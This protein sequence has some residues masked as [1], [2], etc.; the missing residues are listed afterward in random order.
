ML[1][2]FSV[3]A[4]LPTNEQ[5]Q[6]S[7]EMVVE[8]RVASPNDSESAHGNGDERV[9][10]A[11]AE[12][13]TERR[14]CSSTIFHVQHWRSILRLVSLCLFV[15]CF[16]L[17]A[18]FPLYFI[19]CRLLSFASHSRSDGFPGNLIVFNPYRHKSKKMSANAYRFRLKIGLSAVLLTKHHITQTNR[20][21]TI[22][23]IESVA[24]KRTKAWSMPESRQLSCIFGD[25]LHRIINKFKRY[26]IT[27]DIPLDRC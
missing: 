24:Y 9:S 20:K 19:R 11:T 16:F 13:D 23:C 1:W 25:R 27:F 10:V 5:L 21:R 6:C 18:S 26:N 14:I 17:A 22:G 3:V 4:R 12:D 8:R 15:G 2:F 7:E